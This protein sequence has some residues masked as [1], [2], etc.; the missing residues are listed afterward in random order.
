MK[1]SA[2]KCL[3]K[4]ISTLNSLA[5]LVDDSFKDIVLTITNCSGN[6]FFC[7][8]GKSGYIS[9][10]ISGTLSSIGIRSFYMD[11][12]A[13]GHGNSGAIRENDVIFCIS[14]SGNTAELVDNIAHIKAILPNIT[15][16]ALTCSKESKIKH[17]ADIYVS[18]N[19]S[20]EADST[21]IIPTASTTASLVYGDMLSC[22][23]EHET[24]F[25][26]N[27]LARSHPSGEIGKTIKTLK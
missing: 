15:I 27:S 11:C 24:G 17:L 16:I 7:G 6:L 18:I 1:N 23:I 26:L 14:K 9:E 21:G 5:S 25:N 12:T 13:L 2:L 19:L 22:A 3:S 10:K 20:E 4:E 8:I